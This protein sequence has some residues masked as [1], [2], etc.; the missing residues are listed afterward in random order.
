MKRIENFLNWFNHHCMDIVLIL[1]LLSSILPFILPAHGGASYIFIGVICGTNLAIYAYWGHRDKIKQSGFT[2]VSGCIIICIG[3]VSIMIL[4]YNHK[5]MLTTPFEH[6]CCIY[7]GVL[8]GGAFFT[9]AID[10]HNDQKNR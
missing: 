7:T 3:F 6:I 5:Q 8:F 2:T 9:G 10:F 1:T 4:G